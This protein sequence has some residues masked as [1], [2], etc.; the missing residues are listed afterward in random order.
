MQMYYNVLLYARIYFG[1]VSTA[2]IM[3]Y[4]I[5]L[6]GFWTLCSTPPPVATHAAACAAI[7]AG[8]VLSSCGNINTLI[9]NRKIAAAL[10]DAMQVAKI[11]SCRLIP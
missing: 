11:L 8:A 5:G 6:G 10:A 2:N 9:R 1:D 4:A 7:A 3:Y